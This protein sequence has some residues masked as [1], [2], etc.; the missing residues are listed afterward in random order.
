MLLFVGLGNPGRDYAQNR[1]NVGAMAVEAIVRRHGLPALRTRSRP[2]GAFSEG[3]LGDDAVRILRPLSYMNESGRP[4]GEAMRYFRL[5]PAEVIVFHDELDLAAG[6]VRV[7]R[8]GGHAGH[9][10]LRSIAQH[11]GPDFGRVRIGIGHPGDRDRVTGHVLRDF[12]KAD[13]AWVDATLDAIADAAPLLAAGDD[14]GFMTRV[15]LLT[16][17]PRPPKPKPAPG[18]AGRETT[19][20]D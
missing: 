1:H 20:E 10:G 9:N 8:G 18:E 3:R 12:S 2:S 16:R 6:K 13:R 19:D 17:P 15:A 11:I 5:A 7:K 4:V 14:S